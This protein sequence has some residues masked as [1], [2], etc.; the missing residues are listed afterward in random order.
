MSKPLIHAKSSAKHFGG[1]QEDYI[2][3]HSFIDSSKGTVACS[4]HRVLTHTSWFL[5]N[6]LERIKFANSC[7]P[8]PDNRFPFV[9]NSDNREIS[10]RDIGEQHILEDFGGKFIPSF[11][12]Y[13][14]SMEI[15]DWMINGGGIP[16]SYAK[17]HKKNLERGETRKKLIKFD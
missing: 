3:I 13:V 6:I 1:K 17:I 10:V 2:E 11:Q 15:K 5:S 7:P 14:E 16:P 4:R 8:T 12:D 9:I